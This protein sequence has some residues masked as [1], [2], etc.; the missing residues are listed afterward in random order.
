[1]K[2]SV[3]IPF[4]NAYNFFEE[5][6]NSVRSQTYPVQEIIVVNDGCGKK[7]KEFLSQFDDIKIIN[8]EINQGV[9]AA[10]NA[11]IKA[12]TGEWIAFLDADDLWLPNKLKEQNLFIKKHPHFSACHTGITT[13]NRTGDISTYINKPFDLTLFDLLESMQV[14]PPSLLITKSSLEAIDYFDQNILCSEDHDLSIRLVQ[15]GFNIGFINQALTRVRRMDHGNITTNG[16]VILKGQHQ[17]L[18]KHWHAFRQ[19]KGL[20]SQ[21]IYKTL[22]T[23]GGKCTG[24]ERKCLFALGKIMTLIFPTLKTI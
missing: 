13:F 24:I 3:V 17:L 23:A 4:F 12:A 21:Y 9:S 8:F 11:G 19:Y 6:L 7:A 18:K 1:M 16:R 5:T 22:M 15:Q 10:R 14:T 20:T 2:I